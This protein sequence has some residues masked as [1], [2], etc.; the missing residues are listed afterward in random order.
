[1]SKGLV[2]IVEDESDIAELIDFH[3]SRAGFRTRMTPSGREALT[4]IKK[5]K[6]SLVMLDIMLPD[7]DG[8]EVCRKIKQDAA[9]ADVPVIM[10]SARG[11]ESDVV[12]GLELGADD[13]VTKPF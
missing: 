2:L 9:L 5:E 1:M 6:P 12:V 7:L 3:L 13:Y 11:E 8:L 4:L 10:V